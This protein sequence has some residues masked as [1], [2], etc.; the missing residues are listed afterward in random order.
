[1]A[2]ERIQVQCYLDEDTHEALMEAVKDY[3]TKAAVT[4]M[5]LDAWLRDN[6]YLLNEPEGG[7]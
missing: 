1:M 6:G 2:K 7:F 3:G 5:A 4:A